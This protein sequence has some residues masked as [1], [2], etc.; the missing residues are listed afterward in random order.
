MNSDTA[1][2]GRPQCTDLDVLV[3]E[4]TDDR[5][6]RGTGTARMCGR[7]THALPCFQQSRYRPILKTTG[8]HFA[9]PAFHLNA[10]QE[11]SKFS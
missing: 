8:H 9:Q 6:D 2:S 5:R 1:P 3:R 7:A 11:S 4:M 10:V